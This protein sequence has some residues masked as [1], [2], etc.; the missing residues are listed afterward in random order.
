MFVNI[1]LAVCMLVGIV[2][3]AK[4]DSKK[5]CLRDVSSRFYF[6]NSACR[7]V[8]MYL[9]HFRFCVVC[10]S[11]VISQPLSCAHGGEV[12]YFGSFALGVSLV[13]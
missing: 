2:V 13:S 12:M 9:D 4:A 7:V 10:I 5:N 3:R 8:N 6:S 11:G 1:L